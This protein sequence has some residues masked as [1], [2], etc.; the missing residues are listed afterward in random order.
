[1]VNQQ[2]LAGHWNELRG[3]LKEK[4]GK[5]TDDDLRSFNGNVDQLI[6]RIQQKTGESREAI[7]HFLSQIAEE[8]SDFV[9][10]ARERVQETA[11]QVADEMRQGYQNLRQGYAEAEKIVQQR[12]GQSLAVA[13]GIGLL[14]GV[15]VT[16]LLRERAS[17]S[18]YTRGRA[19]TEQ[20]GRQLV[21]AL[22][23][24]LPES[25]TKNRG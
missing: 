11:S 7:E 9:G 23:N 24:L 12:P 10:A 14:A 15:G 6:G 19:A 20:F 22:A 13:F 8:G 1:M 18:T 17:E 21:D 5:L 4:W 25:L 16:L 2:V 3:K